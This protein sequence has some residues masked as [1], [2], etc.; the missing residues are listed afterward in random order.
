MRQQKRNSKIKN[1]FLKRK[2]NKILKERIKGSLIHCRAE[3]DLEVLDIATL[4]QW[5]K[6][7]ASR[8]QKKLRR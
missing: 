1:Y 5:V 8:K 7:D 6:E 3:S 2:T 4:E